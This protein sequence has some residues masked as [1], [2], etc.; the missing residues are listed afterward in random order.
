MPAVCRVGDRHACGDGDATGSGNVM[1]NGAPAHRLTDQHTHD[2]AQ[3]EA[4]PNVLV[5]GLG[6]ARVGDDQGA[7][8]LGHEPNPQTTGSP[9]VFANGGA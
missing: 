2:A 1:V 8:S 3:I 5:N 4:S 9:D 7:D 6:I